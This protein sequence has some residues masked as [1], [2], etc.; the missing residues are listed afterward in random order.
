VRS[1]ELDLHFESGH[2]G[3]FTVY[4]TASATSN[5]TCHYLINCLDLLQ[6]L[7]YLEPNHEV[8]TIVLEFKE[9]AVSAR[10]FG[11][12]GVI[13]PAKH[14]HHL[15]DLD[16]QL[17]EHLGP[18]I[19]TPGELLDNPQCATLTLRQ[20]IGKVG[21]PTL[22]QLRGRYIVTVIGNWEDNYW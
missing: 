15:E 17:W 11:N 13:G 19:Y 9:S 4:H 7:D 2:A 5:S 14:D 10:V 3:E 20:C 16:R 22:D 1:L 18:R 6:R 12:N 8:V 21:W